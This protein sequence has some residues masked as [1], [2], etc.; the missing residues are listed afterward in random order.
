MSAAAPAAMPS[1]VAGAAEFTDME[2]STIRKVGTDS[3]G[4]AHDA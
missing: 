3:R 2:T 4:P 1:M